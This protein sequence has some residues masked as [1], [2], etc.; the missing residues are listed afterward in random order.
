MLGVLNMKWWKILWQQNYKENTKILP[1]NFIGPSQYTLHLQNILPP[2]ENVNVPNIRDNY[3]VTEKADGD[4]KLLFINNKGKLFLIT[5]NMAVQFTGAKTDNKE[6]FNTVID[7]EHILYNKKREFINVYAAF[8]IYY[9]N[10]I[11]S[12]FL[13]YY[14]I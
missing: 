12:T 1:R 6:L 13:S 2:D 11:L 3:T 10:Y 8:D 5:T 14:L 7:G 4:R 9:I